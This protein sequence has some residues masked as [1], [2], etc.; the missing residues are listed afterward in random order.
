[1]KNILPSD[2]FTPD[3]VDES[4]VVVP[5]NKEQKLI[6]QLINRNQPVWELNLLSGQI[7]QA[8]I[9]TV[10]EL[11]GTIKRSVKTND[12]CLYCQS[13]NETNAKKHF[14]RQIRNLVSSKFGLWC[15]DEEWKQFTFEHKLKL[16]QT[17]ISA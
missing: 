17:L 2:D 15:R 4:A 16:L 14:S 5:I 8:K 9:E 11:T 12:K 7:T 13:L 3:K 10:A 1:M 6:G